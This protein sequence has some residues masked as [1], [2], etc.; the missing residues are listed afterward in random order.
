MKYCPNCEAEYQDEINMCADCGLPLIDTKPFHC[1]SCEERIEGEIIFCPHCGIYLEES[2]KT[3]P[4]ACEKHPENAAAGMCVICGKAVC[5]ECSNREEGRIFCD[6]DSHIRI[7]Q[8]YAL[9]YQTSTEYEAAMIQS[10]LEGAGINAK[11][12]SQHDHVYIVNM[13]A[14][15]VVNVMVP[16]SQIREAQ[17]IITSLLSE[18]NR[19]DE[20]PE[21]GT[22]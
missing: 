12:F 7:H 19:T 5:T 14:L 15:A 13:G 6:D 17:E 1:P 2:D 22:A 10:N 20:N 9:A 21:A 11:I 8:D 4:P 16:K 3:A 18:E